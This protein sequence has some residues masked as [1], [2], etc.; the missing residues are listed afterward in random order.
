MVRSAKACWEFCFARL[1]SSG[2]VLIFDHEPSDCSGPDSPDLKPRRTVNLKVDS[3]RIEVVST[4][5]RSEIP[6]T[7]SVDLPYVLKV[8][9]LRG[10]QQSVERLYFMTTNFEQKQRWVAALEHTLCQ[11]GML[12]LWYLDTSL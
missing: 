6:A 2:E 3:S 1:L 5:P 7:S 9:V 8:D 12:M 10:Y 4:V 11:V